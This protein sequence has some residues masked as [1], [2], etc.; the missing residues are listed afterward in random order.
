VAVI[1]WCALL[2]TACGGGGDAPPDQ[3]TQP[4]DCH[5]HPEACK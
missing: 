3:T 2:L 4:V 1:V 5:A